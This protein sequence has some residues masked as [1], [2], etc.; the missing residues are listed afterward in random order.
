MASPFIALY[1][2]QRSSY[3]RDRKSHGPA[4]T[5]PVGMSLHLAGGNRGMEQRW[6]GLCTPVWRGFARARFQYFST[7]ATWAATLRISFDNRLCAER[8]CMAS[9]GSCPGGLVS[10]WSTVPEE[11]CHHYERKV[12]P[13]CASWL[14][15]GVQRAWASAGREEIIDLTA[16][17][18][19]DFALVSSFRAGGRRERPLT[20]GSDSH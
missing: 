12:S 19:P 9:P 18:L 14:S 17:G 3:G 8:S 5:M 7:F 1:S 11:F 4:V 10:T 2:R 6:L 15:Q 16:Q 20:R 13:Q